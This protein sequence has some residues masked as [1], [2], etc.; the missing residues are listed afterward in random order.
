M[1]KA[2]LF[3][4]TGFIV[5]MA[6]SGLVFGYFSV[7]FFSLL[8]LIF[9][10]G[11]DLWNEIIFRQL[12]LHRSFD[13]EK[14]FCNQELNFIIELENKKIFPV[15]WL[16]ITCKM[17]NKINFKNDKFTKKVKTIGQKFKDV[18]NIRWYQKI[19]RFYKVKPVHRGVLSIYSANL[20]YQDPFGLFSNETQQEKLVKVTVYPRV[21][22]VA[23]SANSRDRLFGTKPVQGW[24]F[25]DRLNRMGVKD[26]VTTDSI[27]DINWKVSGK[28]GKLQSNIYKPS[29]EKEVAFFHGLHSETTFGERIQRNDLEI[30][31]IAV[32]SLAN[33]YFNQGFEVSFFSTHRTEEGISKKYSSVSAAADKNGRE[34]LYTLLALIKKRGLL[35]LSELISQKA[36]QLNSGTRVVIF[37][38]RKY[39]FL[40]KTVDKFSSLNITVVSP[41]NTSN[42]LRGVQHLFVNNEVDW[43]EIQKIQLYS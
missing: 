2:L 21:L 13:R 43:N 32:A 16:T 35:P 19:K 20:T 7:F 29:L 33:M 31:L 4:L 41:G 39:Q 36:R 5:I 38:G 23:M 12:F 42:R 34:N 17:S 8:L 9:L 30:S 15:F 22:S 1:S 24:V 14:V 6:L 37:T 10:R 18:F 40:Q 3:G 28:R 27:K 11:L 26:Y 25:P